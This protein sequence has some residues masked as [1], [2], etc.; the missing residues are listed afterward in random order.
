[1]LTDGGA[2]RSGATPA[3]IFVERLRPGPRATGGGPAAEP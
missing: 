2:P 3:V 1:M